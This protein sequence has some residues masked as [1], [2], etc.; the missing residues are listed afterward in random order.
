MYRET[1]GHEAMGYLSTKPTMIITTLHASGIINAGVFGAYTNL[2]GTQIGA[3]I[4][5]ASHTYANIL[6]GRE[7]VINVP[8]ADLVK[9]LAVLADDIPETR[10]ELDE[11]GLTA[12]TGDR[13]EDAVDCRM[14]S[15]GRVCVRAG[16]VD[17]P[18][19][20]DHRQGGRRLD[21]PK[22]AGRR[23]QNQHFQGSRDQGLQVSPAAV[24]AAGRGGG[25]LD[26][27][28]PGVHPDRVKAEDG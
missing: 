21:T 15:G 4:S 17:R 27:G 2:S 26:S 20:P 6:C 8:G 28:R 7:F 12:K 18:P 24:C 3:A 13:P 16:G 25:R 5:V 9:A 14:P 23:R 19:R 22:R 10:S 11:A 1:R